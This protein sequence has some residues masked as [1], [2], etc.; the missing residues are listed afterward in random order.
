MLAHSK[1]SHHSQGMNILLE[2]LILL[3]LFAIPFADLMVGVFA[4]SSGQFTG[5]EAEQKLTTLLPGMA[6]RAILLC[7]LVSVLWR[8]GEAA[9][10]TVIGVLTA[11]LMATECIALFEHQSLGDFIYGVSYLYKLIFIIT[12][13][14]YIATLDSASPIL[15]YAHNVLRVSFAVYTIAVTLGHLTGFEFTTYGGLGSSGLMI[16]GS[17]NSIS[18]IILLGTIFVLDRIKESQNFYN[19]M[20]WSLVFVNGFYAAWLLLTK[21]AIIGLIL[22]AIAYGVRCLL[23]STS[24]VPY[25]VIMSLVLVAFGV[26]LNIDWSEVRIVVRIIDALEFHGGDILQAVF[27]GRL[28]FISNGWQAFLNLYEPYQWVI[29]AGAAGAREA[30]G[31]FTGIVQGVESDFL[32]IGLV[33]GM[34]GFGITVGL[35]VFVLVQ[36]VKVLIRPA[37]VIGHC[38]AFNVILL[39]GLAIIAGHVLTSGL[40]GYILALALALLVRQPILSPRSG[41]IT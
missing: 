16:K 22:P 41:F 35:W 40:G 4:L 1:G 31:E 39:T 33:Y 23:N 29:G 8:R 7:L 12:V 24:P 11:L 25:L 19:S 20:W 26:L 36:A 2:K 18:L 15:R 3:F 28:Y 6:F 38:L 32:D 10:I 27:G 30:V 13:F 17:A 21:G 34:A 37:G 9:A 14:L 5:H